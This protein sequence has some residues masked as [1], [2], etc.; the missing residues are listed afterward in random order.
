MWPYMIFLGNSPGSGSESIQGNKSSISC[1]VNFKRKPHCS[2][3][4]IP[5][6]HEASL[7]G[8][9]WS[10]WIVFLFFF[11]ERVLCDPLTQILA[12]LWMGIT[13]PAFVSRKRRFQES[14]CLAWRWVTNGFTLE[15][16]NLIPTISLFVLTVSNLMQ[17]WE[18]PA[19]DCEVW[20]CLSELD[21][22]RG[23]ISLG[24]ELFI[25]S[26]HNF[27]PCGFPTLPLRM[28]LSVFVWFSHKNEHRSGM[29][30]PMFAASQG[31]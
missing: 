10:D 18:D 13:I 16:L 1:S 20:Q 28:D 8:L 17:E 31:S 27:L 24:E 9:P 23:N 30:P 3:A 6:H 7:V 26:V 25:W 22:Q 21:S 2:P 12:E 5:G 11:F 15:Q 14:I 4:V 29:S 19:G